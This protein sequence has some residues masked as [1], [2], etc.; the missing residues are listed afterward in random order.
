M[1]GTV[2]K[3]FCR[4]DGDVFTLLTA[5]G[6][7][8]EDVPAKVFELVKTQLVL[9]GTNPFKNLSARAKIEAK[10]VFQ[11]PSHY[12]FSDSLALVA[13]T[14]SSADGASQNNY[15]DRLL[16]VSRFLSQNWF[17]K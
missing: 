16:E 10:Q 9:E 15:Y 3:T 7:E 17:Q 4:F 13:E 2:K 1:V 5:I 14:M 6:G 12:A 8:A 11:L